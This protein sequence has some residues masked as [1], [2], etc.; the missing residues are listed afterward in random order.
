MEDLRQL[1][2]HLEADFEFSYSAAAA[3][4]PEI[5][6]D[7]L[8]EDAPEPLHYNGTVAAVSE[9]AVGHHGNSSG[10]RMSGSLSIG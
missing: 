4:S 6:L 5:E 3:E 2:A 10:A 7:P 9:F 8:A 1:P